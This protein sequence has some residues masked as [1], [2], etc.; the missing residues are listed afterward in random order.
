MCGDLPDWFTNYSLVDKRGTT[1]AH[2]L[3]STGKLPPAF[4][5]TGVVDA[6]GRTATQLMDRKL[7]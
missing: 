6:S 3:A 7:P 2:A 5:E 4:V 1:V